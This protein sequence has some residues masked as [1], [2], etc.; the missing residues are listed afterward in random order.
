MFPNAKVFY[1]VSSVIESCRKT[2]LLLKTP[3]PPDLYQ[4]RFY[5][6]VQNVLSVITS[7]IQ[8]PK[9]H[10]VGMIMFKH[11]KYYNNA[12]KRLENMKPWMSEE[13]KPVVKKRKRDGKITGFFELF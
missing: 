4:E 9:Q 11:G 1:D 2:L 8:L 6:I 10:Y 12:K 13:K 5:L 7:L 3:Q